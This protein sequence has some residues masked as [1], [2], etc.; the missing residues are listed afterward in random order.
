MEVSDIED[1]LR[2]KIRVIENSVDAQQFLEELYLNFHMLGSE[3]SKTV[4]FISAMSG[5]I[6]SRDAFE[7]DENV[8]KIICE[9]VFESSFYE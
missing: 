7:E 9:I 6:N 3:H 2:S 4:D 1:A 8:F 5:L